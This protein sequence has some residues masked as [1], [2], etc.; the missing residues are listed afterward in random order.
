MAS[1]NSDIL[2]IIE[3]AYQVDTP[4]DVWLRR[5]SAK[6]KPHLDQGFGMAAF[7]Y[8][9]PRGGSLQMLQSLHIGIPPGLNEIYSKVFQ[10]M[11]P[12]IR[13]RP[14][15][16]GP[17]VSGSQMM[18]MRAEQFRAQPHMKRF[19]QQFGMYDSIWIT[20][21][22][23]SG[24]GLGFH[25]GRA[26]I[27][28]ASPRQVSLWGKVAAHLSSAVRLRHRMEGH[29]AR[30]TPEA[31]LDPS[32]KLHDAEGPAKAKSARERLRAAVRD[33]E[34]GRG[35]LRR[36]DPGQALSDWKGLVAGRW[37]LIDQ[38]ERD[39]RRYIVARENAPRV[40]GPEALTERERQVVGFAKLG[41]S[42][43]LIA[44]DLGIADSTVR[45][46]IARA[47]FK[48]GVRTRD[49]VIRTYAGPLAPA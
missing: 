9:W 15:E 16:M 4:G 8:F 23:P 48:L 46:L 36:R 19:V 37:T 17:C 26:K 28:W 47:A 6:V 18:G 24:R 14:F 34:R 49:E 38:L 11:D 1:V 39:G 30:P 10:T 32:G 45:V 2:S 13:A 27:A 25:S 22:E 42:N 20:A 5:L 3:S 12:Q 35:P 43:K 21:A 7:E 44:Y 41:H 33:I 31:V 29:P 40:P